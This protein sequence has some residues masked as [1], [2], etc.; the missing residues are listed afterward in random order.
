MNRRTFALLTAV[1]TFATGVAIARFS[2][3]NLFKRS[4]PQL[5]REIP[6]SNYRLSGPY[7]FEG[8]SI[9][10]VHGVNE[11]NSRRYMPLEEAMQR[12]TVVVHETDRVNDLEIENNSFTEEVFV[13][14]G[15]ILKGG[16]QDRVLA[17]DLILPTRSGRLPIS[18]FCVESSRWNQRGAEQTDHFTLT[19]M[20]AGFSLRRVIKNVATQV[21]VWSEVADSQEKM[22]AGVASD[23]RSTV[24][25]TSLVLS[26]ENEQL[27]KA[28][29]AYVT[30][31]LAIVNSSND[32]AIGFAFAIDGKLK[33]ADV[34]S[35]NEMFK[36]LWPRLLRTAAVEAVSEGASKSTDDSLS[37]ETVGAFLVNSETGT[38][39]ISDVTSRTRS[40]KR[41]TE[42]TLFFETRDMDH[43]G[44][45]VHRSYLHKTQ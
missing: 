42:Q 4:T 40:A 30:S 14:A 2:I 39:T 10:L 15:D 18:A 5:Q 36:R 3:P 11:P 12:E 26:M 38:E 7:R 24:S 28:A 22:S 23:V 19:E 25:P 21:G 32:D 27:Q 41:E 1:I 9:F 37:S 44:A 45:W 13:Q 33:G 8:L 6:L 17:T 34:Y 29:A 20:S 16:N 31:L 43:G 35:S